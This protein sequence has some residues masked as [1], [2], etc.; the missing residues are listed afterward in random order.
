MKTRHMLAVAALLAGADGA[1]AGCLDGGSI[2]VAPAASA[3]TRNLYPSS[4]TV[5]DFRD[6]PYLANDPTYPVVVRNPTRPSMRPW[7]PGD[8]QSA[9][10]DHLAPDEEPA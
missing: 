8:G 4:R 9:E 2:V 6:K 10:D 5:Y 3:S 7:L 1:A